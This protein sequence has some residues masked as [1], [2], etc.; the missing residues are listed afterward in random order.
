MEDENEGK[1][2][3]QTQKQKKRQRW[4]TT[5]YTHRERRIKKKQIEKIEKERKKAYK[6]K[7]LDLSESIPSSL[8]LTRDNEE[9]LCK[10]GDTRLVVQKRRFLSSSLYNQL[11]ELAQALQEYKVRE[12][13]GV[14]YHTFGTYDTHDP[15]KPYHEP[16]YEPLEEVIT[17]IGHEV[18]GW[19]VAEGLEVLRTDILPT[20]Q[21]RFGISTTAYIT[22]MDVGE[23][24]KEHVDLNDIDGTFEI[25]F[26]DYTGGTLVWPTINQATT[27]R[28]FDFVWFS[29]NTLPHFMKEVKTGVRFALI[30]STHQKTAT[31][32][33]E[34]VE[35]MEKK[36]T[37]QTS[38]E[39]MKKR[40]KVRNYPTPRKEV[41][42][43][44][45][46]KVK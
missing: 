27:M 45:K 16:G 23:A 38:I 30:F 20:E 29:S 22:R 26:G 25:T 21:R 7:S 19:V 43:L 4:I 10:N 6:K 33:R 2:E 17:K 44:E 36:K 39:K 11:F 5:P 13:T 46:N 34:G 1:E 40:K 32:I 24:G 35:V 12:R 14:R 18:L 37:K 8:Q 3:K 31:S 41:E 28:P 15:K 42:L 9:L